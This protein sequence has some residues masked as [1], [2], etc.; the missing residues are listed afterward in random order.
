MN[1]V[2]VPQD[3]NFLGIGEIPEASGIAERF[4]NRGGSH[5]QVSARLVYFTI[6]IIFLAPNVVHDH[7]DIRV[8]NVLAE[9]FGDRLGQL[10]G[11]LIAG[12]HVAD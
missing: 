2:A 3:A 10:H 11:S 6:D 8:I 5:Q 12:L 9:Q 7:I 4:Q 1:N